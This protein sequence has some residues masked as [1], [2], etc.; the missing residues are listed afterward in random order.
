MTNHDLAAIF[1][2]IGTLLELKGEN[3]FKFQAYQRAARAI[4][5]YP[6]P[7]AQLAAADRLNEVPGIGEAISEKIR[8]LLQSGRLRFYDTLRAEFPPGLVAVMDIPGVGPKLAGRFWKELGIESVEDLEQALAEGRVAALPRLGARSAE[9]IQRSIE[10][11]RQRDQRLPI[12]AALSLAVSLCGDLRAAAPVT[13]V[14]PAGSVRRFRETVG[15]IN[16]ACAAAD[17]AAVVRAFVGLPAVDRVVMQ[18]EDRATVLVQSGVEVHLWV[19]REDAFGSLLQHLTGSGEHNIAVQERAR[20][21]GLSV[22]EY[23]ITDLA[24]GALTPCRTEEEVYRRLGLSAIPPEIREGGEELEQAAT[25]TLP[26]LV[27]PADLRGDLHAHTL[28]SDGRSTLEEMVAAARARGY[29]YLAITDH[30]VGRAVANG[31]SVARLREHLAQIRALNARL[32]GQFR[33]LAGSEVDIRADGSLDYPDEVLAELDIV[34]ASVH[35]AMGQDREKMTERV[36]KALCNPHV[37]VL[38]HPTA[39]L[40]G[41]REPVQ[42]DMERV[43]QAALE[44]GTAL[45]INVS[46]PRLDLKDT[47]LRRAVEL[48]VPLVMSTDA[49]H[50]DQL[51]AMET[52]VSHARRGWC[53]AHHI[54]NTRP[55]P[56][57]LAWLHRHGA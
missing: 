15:N 21:L 1:D 29:A 38:G 4:D 48:G 37:D 26:R 17:P 50:T 30:S 36:V 57:L 47:H 33:I 11:L 52:G 23:G 46:L 3:R 14:V 31:L 32:E 6:L 43:F 7:M 45:E 18:G 22:S 44:T 34:V 28:A 2:H 54:L 24:T 35:S 16:L 19:A 20:R 51:A 55:L 9:N 56:E 41:S 12:G 42:L 39:R 25:G 10:A 40:L 13:E 53:T 8:E 49:H 5:H 27:Q